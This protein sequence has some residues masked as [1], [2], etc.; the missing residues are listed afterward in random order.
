MRA[1]L[2]ALVLAAVVTLTAQAPDRAAEALQGRWVVLGG[3]HD[4]KPMDAIKGGVMVIAGTTFEIRTASG[5]MLKGTLRLDTSKRPAQMDLVHADGKV[6]E[7]I[8]E[9]TGD[10]ARLN[11]VEAG[12]ADRRPEGFTTSDKTEASIV[13]LGRETRQP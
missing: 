7:A 11:Y 2:S 10:K 3:E 1:A 12:G 4:G 13:L 9:V 6:W 5:N 8:Y